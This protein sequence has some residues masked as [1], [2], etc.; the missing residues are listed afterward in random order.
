MTS[1][2]KV[3]G[4][5]NTNVID[6]SETPTTFSVLLAGAMSILAEAD[7]VAGRLERLAGR[8]FGDDGPGAAPEPAPSVLPEGAAP[9]LKATLVRI[10]EQISRLRV[11]TD[12]LE[13]LA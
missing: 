10:D 3:S 2:I 5:V 13:R 7:T 12:H 4:Y 11:L 6:S 1:A 8:L 9:S